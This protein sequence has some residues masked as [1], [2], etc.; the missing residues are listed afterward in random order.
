MATIISKMIKVIGSKWFFGLVL[1]VFVGEAA[2]LALTSRFPMA[3]DEAWHL[4]QIQF[5]AQH[6]NPIISHQAASTYK[7]GAMV[8]NPSFLYHYLL[9]FPYRLIRLFTGSVVAQVVLLRLISIALAAASLM[10]MRRL[11]WLLNFSKALANL[12]VFMFALTPIVVV[13]S[14]QIS[15]D[16]LLILAVSLCAYQTVAL[17]KELDAGVF[18]AK[19]LLGLISLGLFSSLIK[20][21]FLPVLLGI[22]ILVTWKIIACW[23]R[24]S[25]AL[26]VGFKNSFAAIGQYTKIGLIGLGL[27]GMFLFVR[28][29]AVNLVK[30]HNPV[31]ECNKVLNV[32]D[33]QKYYSYNRLYVFL[34]Q[35]QAGQTPNTLS[36]LQYSRYWWSLNL[37]E[38][39]GTVLPLQGYYSA[40]PIFF[41]IVVILGFV[42]VYYWLANIK[43]IWQRD[44]YLLSLV[45]V[46]LVYI[47]V[48]WTKSYVSYL[49]LG[50]FTALAGRYLL[51][52]LIYFYAL[53]A[54]GLFHA[55][56]RPPAPV[57]RRQRPSRLSRYVLGVLPIIAALRYLLSGRH[58]PLKTIKAGLALVVI[59]SFLYLG[60]FHQYISVIDPKYGTLNANNKFVLT[61]T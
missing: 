40:N 50:K 10:V 18:N 2:Y 56:Y 41:L 27:L 34:Q 48:L 36:F 58:L 47:A 6:L 30:Y 61:P 15:Y 51:P 54:A 49:Y 28:I 26:K 12:I 25:A 60:G 31:P 33:C 8:Q 44:K 46:G 55:R 43:T 24:N 4:A 17:L 23:R 5:Y 22:V 13:L 1:A 9:S 35:H 53:L 37:A 42:A 32:A 3:Y 57:W 38:I 19:R 16:N 29:Y 59:V 45:F 14:A 52:V 39:F 21:A 20:Y 11:L 7:L